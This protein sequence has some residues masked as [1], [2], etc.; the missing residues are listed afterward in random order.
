MS[1]DRRG[2]A[3]GW[4]ILSS[5]EVQDARHGVM[6][7][8][9]LTGWTAAEFLAPRTGG[10]EALRDTIQ[11]FFNL[12]TRW[13]ALGAPRILSRVEMVA[14]IIVIMGND[15]GA[16]MRAQRSSTSLHVGTSERSCFR[17]P[18]YLST[19]STDVHPAQ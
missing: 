17:R 13:R 8:V 14:Q 11:T 7:S 1:T 19:L 10:S 16:L 18:N 2:L 9:A 4:P 12:T 15:I 3:G 5:P 6:A